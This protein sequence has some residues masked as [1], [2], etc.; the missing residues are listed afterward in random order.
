MKLA[1]RTRNVLVAAAA[2]LVALAVIIGAAVGA[3]KSHSK[4]SLNYGSHPA[5]ALLLQR[6]LLRTSA[7]W[8]RYL[9]HHRLD[10]CPTKNHSPLPTKSSMR[11]SAASGSCPNPKPRFALMI[12]A[13][14]QK[15][16][17]RDSKVK[18]PDWCLS[19]IRAATLNATKHD[20]QQ[21]RCL[22][23]AASTNRTALFFDVLTAL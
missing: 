20:K 22:L 16:E 2:G 8:F 5:L 17:E 18:R 10:T 15:Q 6:L 11:P 23:S 3:H 12:R 19:S 13:S 7:K 9:R 21:T 1:L 4:T 14:L